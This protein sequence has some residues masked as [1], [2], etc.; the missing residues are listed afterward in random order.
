MKKRYYNLLA[1]PALI[2]IV[3]C[4]FSGF[5][6]QNPQS[7][8][9]SLIDQR[10]KILQNAATGEIPARAAEKKLR[11]IEDEALLQ[12]DLEE[13][14]KKK[15]PNDEKLYAVK[16]KEMT[17]KKQFFHY[18]TYQADILWD[19]GSS[20]SQCSYNVVIKEE[21]GSFRLTVFEP[22]KV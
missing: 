8:A 5:S 6:S 7:T 4:I 9:K 12:S 16:F 20:T 11:Q 21:N 13:L 22:T 15:S 18:I 3:F 14:Q 19:M 17:K 1:I 2:V 10:A